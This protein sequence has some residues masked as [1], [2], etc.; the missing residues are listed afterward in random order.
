VWIRIYIQPECP[1]LD[2]RKC[3]FFAP[4][5]RKYTVVI[6]QHAG[7]FFF[8]VSLPPFKPRFESSYNVLLSPLQH[9]G[10]HLDQPVLSLAVGE[11]RNGGNGL[12]DVVFCQRA[13]LRKAGA[14]EYDIA[15][16]KSNCQH[17]NPN[18]C[19]E[20][21]SLT[22]CASPFSPNFLPT[23]FPSVWL[24]FHAKSNG[25]VASPNSRSAPPGL[26]SSSLLMV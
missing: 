5:A 18:R 9:L 21:G 19:R 16:L 10:A 4:Y 6:I 25:A 7:L 3:Q 23:S 20:N 24:S 8:P 15:S 14:G 22:F 11:R 12:V 1:K 26:P 13:G 17:N 2:K